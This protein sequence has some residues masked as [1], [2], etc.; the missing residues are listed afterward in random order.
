MWV[1]TKSAVHRTL[2][3][4]LIGLSL[5]LSGCATLVSQ[6]ALSPPMLDLDILTD[7]QMAA[8]GY[9]SGFYCAE[10]ELS[11]T[12]PDHGDSVACLAYLQAPAYHQANRVLW[13]AE[14]ASWAEQAPISTS[15]MEVR[16]R[17]WPA[18]A[19]VSSPLAES[20]E[21]SSDDTSD[22][23]VMPYVIELNTTRGDDTLSM[24][25]DHPVTDEVQGTYVLIHGFRTNKES[26]FFVA[27]ALRYYGYE[28]IL[29]DL[30]GHGDSSGEFSFSGKPDAQQI[31]ALIDELAPQGPLHLLGMSM[32]GSTATH[33]TEQR[34]DIQSLTL[35]APMLEFVDAFVDAGRAYTRAAHLVPQSTLQ[36]GAQY[37]LDEAGTAKED[38]AVVQRV[39]E[40]N[41]PVLIMGSANDKISPLSKLEKLASEQVT[42]FAV[43][44]RTHHGMILWDSEDVHYWY[45]WIESRGAD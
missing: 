1:S 32:G 9:S 17:F 45:Q 42:V 37:A 25:L 44:P 27:E 40:L 30:F 20:I 10:G 18:A 15:A 2:P 5:S 7:E 28:V 21:L 38:T 24:V 6:G 22:H 11:A 12:K 41:V 35:L 8:V 39:A 29:V 36:K 23:V 4:I 16:L 31:S 19:V 26:L 34:D 14:A 33:L 3:A 43:Q 13:R